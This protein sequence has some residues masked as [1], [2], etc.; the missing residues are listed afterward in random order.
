MKTKKVVSLITM[1]IFALSVVLPVFADESTVTSSTYQSSNTAVTTTADS[2]TSQASNNT[3]VTVQGTGTIQQSNTQ[4]NT[5]S[6]VSSSSNVQSVL[7]QVAN[8]NTTVKEPEKLTKEQKKNVIARIKR[9]NELKTKFNKVNADVNYLKT[10]IEIF[11]RAIRINDKK[12]FATEVRK[13]LKSERVPNTIPQSTIDEIMNIIKQTQTTANE[14]Y[15]QIKTI[16]EQIKSKMKEYEQARKE[17][18]Y[19][20]MMT[21]LTTVVSLYQQK[22]D[23]ITAIR[24]LYKDTFVKIENILKAVTINTKQHKNEQSVVKQQSESNNKGKSN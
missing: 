24:N 9:I 3:A 2:T 13:L 14:K 19:D 11:I 17:N 1:V 8:D 12:F 5:Q 22:L 21:A 4:T 20:K 18:N 23:L 10:K 6:L 15:A 16:S 7:P